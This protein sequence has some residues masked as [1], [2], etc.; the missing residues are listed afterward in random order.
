MKKLDNYRVLARKYRPKVFSD[1]VGQDVLTQTLSNA[2]S[3]NRI[4]HAFILTGMR[5]VGKTTA[6]R[7][8]A[9]SLNCLNIFKDDNNNLLP[10]NSCDQ[11][12]SIDTGNNVDVI[13][14]DAASNTGVGNIREI[15]ENVR[16]RPVSSKYKVYVIDEVH[17][18]ST[19]AFNALLKTLE[20][21]PSHVIFILATT[22]IRKVPITVLSRCQRFDL[23]RISNDIMIKH[24]SNIADKEN[25]KIG[26]LSLHLISD[27]SE[28]SIRDGLSLLDQA[29]SFCGNEISENKVREMLGLSSK[30]EIVTLFL[31]LV[32]GDVKESLKVAR[33]QYEKGIGSDIIIQELMHTCHWLTTYKITGNVEEDITIA[34]KE[35]DELIKISNNISLANLTRIWQ[36]LLKGLDDINKLSSNL[37]SFEMLIIRIT[38]ASHLPDPASLIKS[39]QADKKKIAK[40]KQSNINEKKHG[41]N[42]LSSNSN[43]IKLDDKPIIDEKK[44]KV[45]VSGKFIIDNFNDLINVTEKKD[46]FILRSNLLSNVHIISFEYGKISLRLKKNTSKN[47]IGL[48]SSF[49]SDLTGIRWLITLSE[50]QGQ[51]TIREEIHEQE[52]SVRKKIEINPVISYVLESMPGSIIRNIY[53][54]NDSIVSNENDENYEVLDE[55]Y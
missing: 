2:I 6:A 38:Y 44:T 37:A 54:M 19:A 4:Y 15:I 34:D 11:C 50:E 12:N 48:L 46:E 26:D 16:Y 33:H 35:K 30:L 43:L 25:I 9:R 42:D 17:M 18:L 24:L 36:M 7:I 27:A 47:F 8:I 49:L 55:E 1:L 29:I 10:C 28:G 41:P 52:M 31:N 32:K 20:E 21:P 23:S 40:T 5:G 3:E 51:L 13:E 22:E 14:I 39:I 45:D 53:E